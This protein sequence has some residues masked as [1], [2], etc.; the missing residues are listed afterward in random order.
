MSGIPVPHA[1]S[2]Y[3]DA[4]STLNFVIN[5]G[6][7]GIDDM[8]NETRHKLLSHSAKLQ[9]TYVAM[10]DERRVAFVDRGLTFVFVTNPTTCRNSV[11][12]QG[13]GIRRTKQQDSV[14]PLREA[15]FL[16]FLDALD[17]IWKQDD[18][19]VA[20]AMSAHASLGEKSPLACLDPLLLRA[21]V[22]LAAV[23]VEKMKSFQ[24]SV[25]KLRRKRMMDQFD[26][27]ADPDYGSA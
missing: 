19:A 5:E 11:G 26:Y 12:I 8:V 4:G 21:I 9:D 10:M 16:F 15:E 22:D 1:G 23:S 18:R 3:F 7:S 13:L 27:A 24:K 6:L 17:E 2:L 25:K 14:P 20:L